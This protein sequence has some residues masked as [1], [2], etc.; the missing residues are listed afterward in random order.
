MQQGYDYDYEESW[1]NVDEGEGEANPSSLG[2]TG[3]KPHADKARDKERL[4]KEYQRIDP[5]LKV[6][7]NGFPL[8]KDGK[9][10]HRHPRMPKPPT[11]PS[12]GKRIMR[13]FFTS[14]RN[15]ASEKDI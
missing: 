14:W 10:E 8:G 1:P 9:P 4:R 2:K 11:R 12:I 6:D 5:D 15:E 13:R 3:K 7:S